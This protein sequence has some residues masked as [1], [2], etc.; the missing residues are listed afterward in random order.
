MMKDIFRD[1]FIPAHEADIFFDCDRVDFDGFMAHIR[2][3]LG[4]KMSKR[5]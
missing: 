5:Y 4:A 3:K 2:V 1:A